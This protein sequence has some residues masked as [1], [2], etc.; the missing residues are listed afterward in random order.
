MMVFKENNKSLTARDSFS[1]IRMVL[2]FF[3][4]ERRKEIAR[5][6]PNIDIVAIV[7]QVMRL[8]SNKRMVKETHTLHLWIT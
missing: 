8:T 2:P 4:I 3:F 6:F 7:E 5:T 1:I